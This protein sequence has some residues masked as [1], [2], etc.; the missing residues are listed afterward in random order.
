MT[1]GGPRQRI[2]DSLAGTVKPWGKRRAAK[3][4][5]GDDTALCHALSFN[6]PCDPAMREAFKLELL[7]SEY[8][9]PADYVR[10]KR[11]AAA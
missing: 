5:A 9:Y 6:Q 3:T 10:R 2:T 7:K 8:R 4:V 11:R 1:W